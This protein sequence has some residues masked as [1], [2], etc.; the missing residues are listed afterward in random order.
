MGSNGVVAGLAQ[1]EGNQFLN[2][3]F[4]FDDQDGGGHGGFLS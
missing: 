2:G 1:G 4:V 3:R